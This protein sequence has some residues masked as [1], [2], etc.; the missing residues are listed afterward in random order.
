M[1]EGMRAWFVMIAFV[2]CCWQCLPAGDAESLIEALAPLDDFGGQA[3]EWAVQTG[4]NVKL[5]VAPAEAGG[6]RQLVCRFERLDP[7]KT[8][9]N[10]VWFTLRRLW[11]A[12]PDCPGAEGVRIVVS[13]PE[14]QG[15]YL[16]F[17]FLD[18]NWWTQYVPPETAE[19]RLNKL[20]PQPTELLLPFSCLKGK[21]NNKPLAAADIAGIVFSGR[22]PL[23]S[24]VIHELTFYRKARFTGWVGF[25]S[26]TDNPSNLFERGQRVAFRLHALSPVPAGVAALR[27]EVRDYDGQVA[28][29][30]DLE[31]A[32]RTEFE[33]EAKDLL[34]GYY[35]VRTFA[36]NERGEAQPRS[37]LKTGFSMQPGVNTFAV[38]PGTLAENIARMRQAGPERAF[39]GIQNIMRLHYKLHEL[40]GMP[41]V[42]TA[43]RWQ[44][45][46][47][48][49]PV[50]NGD[51][52]APWAQQRL[53]RDQP[54]PDYLF[55]LSS[56]N[57]NH[58]QSIP[59]WARS[60]SDLYP[61]F[62]SWDDLAA[63][64]KDTARVSMHQ[65]PA[66]PRRLYETAWEIHLNRM[67]WGQK[68]IYSPE[69]VVDLAKHLRQA[70]KAVDPEA[71]IVGAGFGTFGGPE[72]FAALFKHGLLEQYD[73][74]T[75]HCY[76]ATPEA[77]GAEIEMLRT[78]MRTAGK[79][80]PIY[81]T[82]CG[83]TSF[84][85]G[86]QL[87]LR[88][89]A[90]LHVRQNIVLKG[91][92]LKF[93]LTFYPF[94]YGTEGEGTYGLFFYESG[95]NVSNFGPKTIAPKPAAAALAACSAQLLDTRPAGKLDWWGAPAYGYVFDR[96][97]APVLALWSTGPELQLP[98]P[99]GDVPQVQVVDIMG[100]ARRV[101]A[102]EG[103]VSLTL[104]ADP[105]Y[106]NG[107]AA[108]LYLAP[109]DRGT[110]VYPGQRVSLAG[111]PGSQVKAARTWGA[112][113]AADQVSI[114]P[115]T[116]PGPV[117]L[118]LSV[119]DAQGQERPWVQWLLVKQPVELA[120]CSPLLRDGRLGLLLKLRNH[121]DYPLA[122]TMRAAV[123]DSGAWN[124]LADVALAAQAEA[125]P[126]LPLCPA[127]TGIDPRQIVPA[128]IRIDAGAGGQVALERNLS[129]LC[130]RRADAAQPL[131][132]PYADHV[133]LTGPGSSKQSEEADIAF[134]WDE[135]FLRLQI[136]RRDDVQCQPFS[137]SDLWRGDSIQLAF[138]T[139]PDSDNLYNP[140]AF[141]FSK[142]VTELGFSQTAAGPVCWRYRT[143]NA[144]ELPLGA[145]PCVELQWERPEGES[146][147][148]ISIAIPWPEIG[149]ERVGTGRQIGI[150][151][152]VNDL[153]GKQMPRQC[154]S[155][156]G[157][158]DDDK[159]YK[160]LGRLTL[161]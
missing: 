67:P 127:G 109:G 104:S 37:C 33:V 41:W 25:T 57:V 128:S 2:G 137:G 53:D 97:G 44:W 75:L 110:A 102:V 63:Y 68:P 48:S 56:F 146:L 89:Q 19:Y 83:Y 135:R 138:D 69:Q 94:D 150:S 111:P 132:P 91:E 100:R 81:D 31:L 136:R 160:R 119:A 65:F 141:H 23:G 86:S 87:R 105:I 125:E 122:V 17:G 80:V 101:P 20:G 108:E 113:I 54:L 30:G 96:N 157:G 36:L 42:M 27:Y 55:G 21:G 78:C 93:H 46:E 39:F 26:L 107:A 159:S 3:R 76:T 129:F 9:A 140:I 95:A 11:R 117:P 116:P 61:G 70:I 1:R 43:P 51:A 152:L 90:R 145:I 98:L 49:K 24:V 118:L 60:S 112:A 99:V 156:F 151:V 12:L 79:E 52:P 161:Q 10:T 158:I 142:K 32:G 35:E 106:V 85:G 59:A 134:A 66:Q 14:E 18:R 154:L 22:A 8:E 29:Q 120:A 103:L 45:D 58:L 16:G 148:L 73:G 149:L 64:V 5:S 121:A 123:R 77:L 114:A 74:I 72:Y 62:A 92:G 147:T 50:R 40:L 6:K 133:Q 7:L 131:T 88:D 28:A 139:D 15:T 143:H 34:P 130:A 153:D 84:L 4:P 144:N 13:A 124:Q 155:L 47:P 82:E 71:Q 115:N 38:L 126:F